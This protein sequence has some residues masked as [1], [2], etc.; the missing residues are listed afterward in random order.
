MTSLVDSGAQ[1][2]SRLLELGLAQAFIDAI[3]NHGVATLSQ[4]AFAL[5]QPGQ[6]PA[7]GAVGNFLQAALGRVAT[8]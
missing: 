5:G 1:F 8:L 6:P 4:L 7:D 2:E 3:K